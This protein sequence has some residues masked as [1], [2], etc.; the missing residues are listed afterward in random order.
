MELN[1]LPFIDQTQEKLLIEIMKIANDSPKSLAFLEESLPGRASDP[2]MALIRLALECISV[3][4][5]L[6][7]GGFKEVYEFLLSQ[8][9]RFPKNL[10]FFNK[11][12]LNENGLIDHNLKIIQCKTVIVNTSKNEE[13]MLFVLNNKIDLLSNLLEISPKNGVFEL[14]SPLFSFSID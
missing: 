8:N 1:S 14:K 13:I 6:F 4:N 2:E 5:L 11:S 3:W 10:V 7:S 9:T 12:N